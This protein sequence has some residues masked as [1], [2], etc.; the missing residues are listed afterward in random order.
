MSASSA[1]R[2]SALVPTTFSDGSLQL[3][4][5]VAVVLMTLDH[6]NTHIWGGSSSFA[7]NLGRL[8]MPIFGVVFAFNLARPGALERHAFERLALRLIVFGMVACVPYMALN[9]SWPL[10]ILFTFLMALCVCLLL[11]RGHHR[12]AVFFFLVGGLLVEYLWFGISLVV[13][14]WWYFKQPTARRLV[15][16]MLAWAGLVIVNGN[17]SA[18]LA[19]PLVWLLSL[20][21]VKLPR[22]RWAFYVYYPAH[23]VLLVLVASGWPSLGGQS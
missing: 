5:L 18:L 10:N 23:L 17:H 21:R 6:I 11:E 12:F 8:A 14:A 2:V 19:I 15:P 16:L 4:K 3:M 13:A 22:S 1:V 9:G 7:F 20:A